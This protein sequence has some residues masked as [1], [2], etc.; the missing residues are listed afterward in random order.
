M[1]NTRTRTRKPNFLVKTDPNPTRSQKALL[2][3][4]WCFFPQN[5][6]IECHI[7][8]KF[9]KKKPLMLKMLIW[10]C[11]WRE[12]SNRRHNRFWPAWLSYGHTEWLWPLGGNNRVCHNLGLWW[13]THHFLWFL[14]PSKPWIYIGHICKTRSHTPVNKFDLTALKTILTS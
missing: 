5:Q 11:W 2:V 1:H 13:D 9:D 3:K 12:V 7:I 10:V 8:I 14:H 6:Q 4:A